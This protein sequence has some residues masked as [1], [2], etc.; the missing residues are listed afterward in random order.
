V[1]DMATAVAASG[2]L[3][4]AIDE[5]RPIPEGWALDSAGNPT[6]DP[7]KAEISLPLG[8]PKGAGLA[9]M[10]ECLTGI[11]A[12]V[13]AL[14]PQL[15]K[16]T[17]RHV[18]N[19]SLIAISVEKFR[20][21]AGFVQ[22]VAALGAEIKKQPR[23]DG[24]DE[25]LLPGERGTREDSERRARGIPLAAKLWQELVAL[26]KELGVEPPGFVAKERPKISAPSPP[27]RVER[28]RFSFTR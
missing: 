17:K 25:L 18:Q 16:P 27:L 6:T 2:K 23:L 21:L 20:P 13:P 12:G 14:A 7:A 19:A 3:R 5:G 9:L 22:D 10:F 11:L 4:Q 1:L 15:A 24:F 28:G 8:G 26:G